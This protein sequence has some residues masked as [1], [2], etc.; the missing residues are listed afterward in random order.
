MLNFNLKQLEAFVTAAELGSFTK[1][2]QALYLTQSTVSAHIQALERALGVSL[3]SRDAKKKITVSKMGASI[4]PCAKDILARCEALTQIACPGADGDSLKIAA[5]SV[6]S[7]CV[8]PQLMASFRAAHPNSRYILQKCDSTQVHNLLAQREVRIGF[9]GNVL[10]D[11][12]FV[13]HRLMRDKLVLL[14]PN[15]ARFR[16][17]QRKGLTGTDLLTEPMISREHGSGTRERFDAYLESR[18][19]DT[20][21]LNIV[22]Q[23]DQPDTILS[24]V[25]SGVGIAPFSALAANERIQLGSILA[26]ELGSDSFYRELYL[27]TERQATL[28]P[29]ERTFAAFAIS[30][31]AD[32]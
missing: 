4:Y 14:T 10:D 11:R 13:Y 18:G 21:T 2:A 1:A 31:F 8:L 28:N 3:F 26:F 24:A 19:F 12:H 32:I 17:A 20:H 15:T 6:P 9:V 7:K 22:A 16:D 29:L 30:M 5:S 27:V 25:A 23:I